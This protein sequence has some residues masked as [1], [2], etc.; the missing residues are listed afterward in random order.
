VNYIKRLEAQNKV[1]GEALN[2]YT[3]ELARLEQY[4]ASPK[5]HEDTTV[6][7]SDVFT[8]LSEIRMSV[9]DVLFRLEELR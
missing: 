2:T 8:R 4:L 7:V 9:G 5:F 1:L 6:Q 3:R